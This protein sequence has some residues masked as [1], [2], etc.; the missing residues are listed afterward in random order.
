MGEAAEHQNGSGGVEEG[1]FGKGGVEGGE[2][3]RVVG[4]S[5]EAS[6]EG[7]EVLGVAEAGE[8]LGSGVEAAGRDGLEE[9]GRNSDHREAPDPCDCVAIL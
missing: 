3:T 2:E 7:G 8:G 6:D 1:C 5:G 9:G 4:V